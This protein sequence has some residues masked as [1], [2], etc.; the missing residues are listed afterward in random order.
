M[1]PISVRSRSTRRPSPQP[2]KGLR[3]A[4]S[5]AC[6]G[7]SRT[8]G[9]PFALALTF[10]ALTVACARPPL[11]LVPVVT[12]DTCRG[13]R[14]VTWLGPD[15]LRDRTLLDDWCRLVGPPAIHVSDS[16]RT[17]GSDRG[18][19]VIASW[20]TEVGEGDLP[21]FLARLRA[22][23]LTDGIPVREFVV[24]L[25]EVRRAGTAVPSLIPSGIYVP[26]KLG[27]SGATSIETLAAEQQL[28]LFYAPAMRNG[29]GQEDRGNAIL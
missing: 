24:L 19:L 14:G 9:G 4:S 25:Q 7:L 10:A 13:T 22:G 28:N 29:G 1:R 23:E 18:R 2:R 11:N 12:S 17:P 15:A 21:A 16:P 20:N 6:R 5:S 26:A 3:P 8:F 27:P